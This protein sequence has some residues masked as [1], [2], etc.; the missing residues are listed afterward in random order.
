MSN[1]SLREIGTPSGELEGSAAAEKAITPG[2]KGDSTERTN[3]LARLCQDSIQLLS[4]L[5]GVLEED[6][7]QAY[8]GSESAHE[9]SRDKGEGTRSL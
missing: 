1:W 9:R 2:A 8:I 6:F 7:G 4:M 3:G 5:D